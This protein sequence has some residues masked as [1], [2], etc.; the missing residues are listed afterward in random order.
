MQ[1]AARIA[2]GLAAQGARALPRPACVLGSR[3]LPGCCTLLRAAAGRRG[4][5]TLVQGTLLSFKRPPGVAQSFEVSKP[6][7]PLGRQHAPRVWLQDKLVQVA[8][9]TQS[10]E[11]RHKTLRSEK[12]DQPPL[13]GSPRNR[14]SPRRAVW[15]GACRPPTSVVGRRFGWRGATKQGLLCLVVVPVDAVANAERGVATVVDDDLL[16]SSG[17]TKTCTFTPLVP[18]CSTMW[19]QQFAVAGILGHH[20]SAGR[21]SR[22]H[23][24]RSILW[25][26]S[27][28]HCWWQKSFRPHRAGWERRAGPASN[29]L[30]PLVQRSRPGRCIAH[31]QSRH[32]CGRDTGKD[33]SRPTPRGGPNR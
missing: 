32:R 10:P 20:I 7:V 9:M 33:M 29:W 28:W 31:L 25:S 6:H 4:H 26:W 18:G 30:P 2:I 8:R 11:G 5:S 16:G 19:G 1:H 13:G 14:S 27:R 17:S 22:P 15:L 21:R 23:R 12:V 3:R 24:R